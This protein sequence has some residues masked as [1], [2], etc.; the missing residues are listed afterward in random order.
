MFDHERL[1]VYQLSLE[2]VIIAN[3]VVEQLPRGWGK[4]AD[5]VFRA[6]V[7]KRIVGSTL[8]LPVLGCATN[9]EFFINKLSTVPLGRELSNIRTRQLIAG[10]LSG[11]P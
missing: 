11:R 3:D 9:D 8:C 2:C 5:Q 6:S 4:L 1:E 10:L 7:T